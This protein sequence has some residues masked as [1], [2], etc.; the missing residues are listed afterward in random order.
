[1]APPAI[2]FCSTCRTPIHLPS[3]A[4]ASPSA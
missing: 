2:I 3:S 4:A 1:M